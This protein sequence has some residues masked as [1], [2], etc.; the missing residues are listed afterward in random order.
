MSSNL[1][2]QGY[3]FY[4][5]GTEEKRIIDTNELA[6]RRLEEL[7]E[8][9][10]RQARSEEP[11]EGFVQG[12]EATDVSALLDGADEG[13]TV[14]KAEASPEQS[15]KAEHDARILEDA[16]SQAH[17]IVE[18]AKAH[19]GQLLLEAK[20]QAEELK[21][22]ATDEGRRNGYQEGKQK[23][24]AEGEGLKQRLLARE[25]QLEEEYQN[26]L[27]QMEP[28]LVEAITDIYEHIFDVELHSYRDILV[29]LIASTLRKAEGNKDFLVH[30]SREDYSY[31]SMQKKQLQAILSGNGVSLEI[32]EDM[33]VEKDECM[34]ETEGAI[35]DCGLGTQLE[36]LRRKLL[37]L[38]YR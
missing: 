16:N 30:V 3:S 32:V 15:Q 12:L 6:A 19:A 27:N 38:A 5:D 7:M 9:M 18:D 20:E 25:A 34:I 21:R 37:L 24:E 33:T 1:L 11:V 10:S 23:A 26:A 35:F 14:L 17:T 36:Q 29:H 4:M 28:Q 22:I 13:S 31:V 8:T 2:K